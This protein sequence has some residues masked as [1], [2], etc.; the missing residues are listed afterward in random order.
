MYHCPP[1]VVDFVSESD[2]EDDEEEEDD[3]EED[4]DDDDDEDDDDDDD[5]E[6]TAIGDVIRAGEAEN[7][8]D[9]EDADD[10]VGF[11]VGFFS[12]FDFLFSLAFAFAFDLF[13][14]DTF[15]VSSSIALPFSCLFHA[16]SVLVFRFSC[17]SRIAT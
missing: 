17:N 4:D 15:F 9:D 5:E 12:S 1:Q 6:E 11:F 14:F 2:D 10:G 16:L 8:E 13:P 3:D 7:L